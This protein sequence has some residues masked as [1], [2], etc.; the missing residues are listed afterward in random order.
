AGEPFPNVVAGDAFLEILREI[1]LAGVGVDRPR[2]RRA[3]PREVRAALVRVD[4]VGERIDGLRVPVIPLQRDLGVDAVLVAAYEDR[5]L[6]DGRLVLVEMLDERDDAPVV[7]EFVALSVAL[8]VER[9]DNAPVEE[10]ELAQT[11]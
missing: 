8:V 10:R 11:L 3:E 9:D 7:V 5:L 4:V 6:V 2:Q 1:V